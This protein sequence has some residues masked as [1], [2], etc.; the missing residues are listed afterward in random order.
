MFPPIHVPDP[1][2]GLDTHPWR[3][4]F[5]APRRHQKQALRL[6]PER[7]AAPEPLREV[8]PHQPA[9]PGILV[10]LAAHPRF[11]APLAAPSLQF[12]LR[13]M[14]GMLLLRLGRALLRGTHAH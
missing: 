1:R 6:G 11:A 7:H 9:A 4:E 12:S 14:A 13:A 3:H 5:R 2:I 8:V 10:P